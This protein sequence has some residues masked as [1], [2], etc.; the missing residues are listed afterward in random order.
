[1]VINNMPD[2]IQEAFNFNFAHKA[3][4]SA[5]G[6]FVFNKGFL[7]RMEEKAM[8][9]QQA[10]DQTPARSVFTS[11]FGQVTPSFILLPV[12][13]ENLYKPS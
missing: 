6:K 3:T 8:I 11:M 10:Q 1:M 7:I 9:Y 13:K 12:F 2:H 5:C 4:Y